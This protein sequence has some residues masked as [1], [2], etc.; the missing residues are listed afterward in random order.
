MKAILFGSIGSIVETSELQ[1][2]AFNQTFRHHGLSW[3]WDVDEY[4]SL[5]TVSGGERRIDAYAK[6]QGQ[7]VDARALHAAKTA[8]FQEL[9]ATSGLKARSGVA[10]VCERASEAGLK[11]GLVS[12]T[13]RTSLYQALDHADGLARDI[14][15]VITA[16]DLRLPQKPLPDVYH[17]AL[18]ALGL[19][20]GDCVAIEDNGPGVGAALK[21]GLRCIAFPGANTADHDFSGA[22][23][24][25][26]NGLAEHI[27]GR[28]G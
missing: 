22:E 6:R 8:L 17:F 23:A 1:R 10:E 16:S 12:T 25:T 26:F 14:F 13:S 5:L 28:S 21:A 2:E 3:H 27:F 18:N 9:L 7:T 4:R 11:L 20:A 24:I 15:D 19:P